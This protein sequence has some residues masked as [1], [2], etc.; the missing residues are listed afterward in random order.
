MNIFL[1]TS[2]CYNFQA[3]SIQVKNIIF[4]NFIIPLMA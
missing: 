4:I 2:T 1:K 3:S